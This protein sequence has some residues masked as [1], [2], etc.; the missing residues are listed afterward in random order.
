MILFLFAPILQK[1]MNKTLLYIIFISLF[2][3]QGCSSLIEKDESEMTAQEF[4]EQARNAFDDQRWESAISYYEKLKAHFPY[5]E[6]AEQAYLDLAYSYYRFGEPESAIMK[7]EE[8]IRLF[9]RHQ[10]LAYAYYLKA[11]SADSINRSWLDSWLTDPARRDMSSTQ[12][13]YNAYKTITVKFPDS[14]YDEVSRERLIVLHNRMARHE[15]QVA[16]YYFERGAY[17]AAVNRGRMV[18]TRYPRSMVNLQALKLIQKSYER[19]GM[20]QGAIDAQKVID[21]NTQ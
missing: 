12:D 8:F 9:P 4:Y 20:T 6:H 5:G 13:A 3:L 19:L 14:V 11:L 10:A 15:F 1:K 16:E 2:M 17:L 21:L 7:L 18:L